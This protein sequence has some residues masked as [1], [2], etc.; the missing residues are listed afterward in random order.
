M[1]SSVGELSVADAPIQVPLAVALHND[2]ESWARFDTARGEKEQRNVLSI[3][4]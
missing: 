4:L 2:I 3:T 1:D